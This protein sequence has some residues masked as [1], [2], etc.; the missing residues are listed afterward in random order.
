MHSAARV[1]LDLPVVGV[2]LGGAGVWVVVVPVAMGG[3][4][5]VALMG[6]EALDLLAWVRP[7]SLAPS[8]F[9]GR[10]GEL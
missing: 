9:R 6:G 1:V 8:N 5:G 4:V 10:Q 7:H 2:V 3:G